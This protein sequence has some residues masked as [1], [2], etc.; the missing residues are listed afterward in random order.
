M[1]ESL[2]Y[3]II[4]IHNGL[5]YTINCL[6]NLEYLEYKNY[7]TI[8][9]DDGST[10]N[11]KKY[12]IN[13]YPKIKI[14]E[15]S[16]NL[17]W[18]GSVEIGVEYAINRG[19]EYICLLNN[20]NTF[21]NDFL[22]Q[23]VTTSI[24]FNIPMVC[25]KVV[26]LKDCKRIIYTG[27]RINFFGSRM[28]INEINKGQYCDFTGGMGVLIRKDVLKKIK[29]DSKTFPHYAGDT[30]FFLRAKKA[31]YKLYYQPKSL[32]YSNKEQTGLT[33][34]GTLSNFIKV[35]IERKSYLNLRKNIKFYYRHSKKIFFPYLIFR[36]YLKVFFVFLKK[37]FYRYIK[38]I[39]LIRQKFNKK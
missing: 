4:P 17:W 1:Y 12:I 37:F 27:G 34:D 25:S 14:L 30:D 11:S 5:K 10:D 19:C 33:I 6:K 38:N 3:I 32:I 39:I 7:K 24:Q 29:F 23:L 15:G 2:V 28:P 35:L 13:K 36:T 26:D 9:I 8:V 21:E 16:G 22:K 18:T 31:G 20:D